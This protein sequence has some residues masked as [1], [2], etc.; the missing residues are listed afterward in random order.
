MLRLVRIGAEGEW[1]CT[2][3]LEIRRPDGLV[4]IANLGLTLAEAK[5]L[6]PAFNGKSLSRRPGTTPFGGRAAHA[7]AMQSGGRQ[8]FGAVAKADTDL[9]TLIRRNL[10]AVGRTEGTALTAFTDG[11]P[12]LRRSLADAGVTTRPMLDC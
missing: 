6:L 2:D 8:V 4:D 1:P 11:C 3:V 5:P 12:G 7:V 10:D 9:G